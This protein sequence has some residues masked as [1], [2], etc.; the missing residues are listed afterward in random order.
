MSSNYG[1][2]LSLSLSLSTISHSR[3]YRAGTGTS[4]LPLSLSSNLASVATTLQASTKQRPASSS[5]YT[6]MAWFLVCMRMA[7]SAH[8]VYLL[9]S[10][11]VHVVRRRWGPR[12]SWP[13]PASWSSSSIAGN[14]R[15]TE[16]SIRVKESEVPGTTGRHGARRRCDLEEEIEPHRLVVVVGN[17]PKLVPPR[18][19]RSS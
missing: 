1:H 7:A 16:R 2:S 8:P 11:R 10:S 12:R 13:R 19:L 6:V 4:A 3:Q 17:L 5:S 14:P 15:A 18:R 9:N